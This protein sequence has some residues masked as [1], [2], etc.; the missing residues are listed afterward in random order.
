MQCDK[1]QEVLIFLLTFSDLLTSLSNCRRIMVNA[2]S[3]SVMSYH[4]LRVGCAIS[5]HNCFVTV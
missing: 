1:E 5:N 3:N 4:Y 2:I